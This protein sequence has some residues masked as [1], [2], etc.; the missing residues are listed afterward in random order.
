MKLTGQT[1]ANIKFDYGYDT[2]KQN[3]SVAH[4]TWLSDAE[5]V[6]I[7]NIARNG[8][9]EQCTKFKD[10]MEKKL[11]DRANASLAWY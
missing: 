11:T 8:T 1:M 6:E 3:L 5:R 2:A 10:M 4:N 7:N 9:E